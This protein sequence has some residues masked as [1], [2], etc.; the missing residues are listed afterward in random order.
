MKQII[1]QKESGDY[2]MFK[3]NKEESQ[4]IENACGML[5]S[6]DK[7][8][9]INILESVLSK[10]FKKSFS[11]NVVE[12]NKRKQFFVMYVIPEDSVVDK[13]T[14]SVM[15]GKSNLNTMTSLW[16]KCEKWTV[17]IDSAILDTKFTDRELTALILHEVGHTVDTNS[18]PMRL[19][20][21]ISFKLASSNMK[22]SKSLSSKVYSSLAKIPIIASCM[23]DENSIK[24]E[25][26]ADK[27][28]SACGY[29]ID[30]VSAINKLEGMIGSR[31]PVSQGAAD[32]SLNTVGALRNRKLELVKES[33]NTLLENLPNNTMQTNV[34]KF[35]EELKNDSE[36][37]IYEK[38]DLI[39]KNT[40]F[41]EFLNIT[42]KKLD[43]IKQSQLDYI[44]AK[45]DD[46]DSV[47][48]K[49]AL[50]TY[51]NSK[52]ELCE[53]YLELLNNPVASKRYV[54]P[55]SEKQLIQFRNQLNI[56]RG[57]IFKYKIQKGDDF[58][59]FYPDKYEG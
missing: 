19:T 9:G 18:V 56:L 53:Y 20:N 59:V 22:N 34:L 55:N 29:A 16:K 38:A 3:L 51:A 10:S 43:K 44:Q 25:I 31:N 57:M 54:I 6:G 42:K 11:V 46:I 35:G 24:K 27:F 58:V 30:L 26:K 37:M 39:V 17:E 33:V 48:D 5:K 28:A 41:T 21:I 1:N 52:L 47:D 23:Y 13:I 7:N 8:E 2:Y 50:L 45:I 32:F 4:K 49:L 36:S 40:Y 12:T 15:S 14:S